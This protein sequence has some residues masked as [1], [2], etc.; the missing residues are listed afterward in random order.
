MTLCLV[1]GF[2]TCFA[3]PRR[4]QWRSVA[5]RFGHTKKTNVASGQAHGGSLSGR[6]FEPFNP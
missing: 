4:S 6:P 2:L 3:K 1:A 5:L